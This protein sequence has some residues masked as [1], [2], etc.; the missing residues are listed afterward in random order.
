MMPL[1]GATV[2]C[3]GAPLWTLSSTGATRQAGRALGVCMHVDAGQL[4]VVLV[5]LVGLLLLLGAG[6]CRQRSVV[7]L[8][9]ARPW[10]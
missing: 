8:A 4:V 3:W 1:T 5:L 6:W 10:A 7:E 2:A 9:A